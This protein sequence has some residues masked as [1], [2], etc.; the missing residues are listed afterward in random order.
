MITNGTIQTRE[1]VSDGTPVT[2]PLGIF[3][4]WNDL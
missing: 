2:E 1:A 4:A 3:D